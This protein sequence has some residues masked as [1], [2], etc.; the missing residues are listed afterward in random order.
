MSLLR[1]RNVS[2]VPLGRH[3]MVNA[4]HDRGALLIQPFNQQ[5]AHFYRWFVTED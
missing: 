3:E 2:T 1:T 5:Y 4:F